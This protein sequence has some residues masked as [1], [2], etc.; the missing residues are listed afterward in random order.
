[1]NCLQQL[2][3]N[4]VLTCEANKIILQYFIFYEFWQAYQFWTQADTEGYFLIKDA[5]PGN[6]TLYAWVP[7]YIGN[8][9]SDYYINISPGN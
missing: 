1:M 5:R 7:G 4:S 6:Y 2:S 8:Y 9:K 3:L